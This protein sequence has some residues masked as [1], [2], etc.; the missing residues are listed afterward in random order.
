MC[1]AYKTSLKTLPRFL[2]SCH[3]QSVTS[4]AVRKKLC[5]CYVKCIRDRFIAM[6]ANEIYRVLC[7]SY[8]LW[9][10]LNHI[11]HVNIY[12][13]ISCFTCKYIKININLLLY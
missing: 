13:I 4:R 9:I 3:V 12:Q 6:V 7:A 11:L 1:L 10:E 5:L 8:V 2:A